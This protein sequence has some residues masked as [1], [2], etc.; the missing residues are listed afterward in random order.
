MGYVHVCVCKHVIA[1]AFLPLTDG[2]HS[3]HP[4]AARLLLSLFLFAMAFGR[5]SEIQVD[6]RLKLLPRGVSQLSGNSAPCCYPE[7]YIPFILFIFIFFP[8]FNRGLSG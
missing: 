7:T 1:A 2:W 5:I 3:R 6:V 4:S 8:I